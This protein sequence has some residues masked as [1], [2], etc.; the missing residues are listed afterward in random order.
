[1]IHRAT[2]CARVC[3]LFASCHECIRNLSALLVSKCPLS[4]HMSTHG[5]KGAIVQKRAETLTKYVGTLVLAAL[6]FAACGEG[7]RQ[8]RTCEWPTEP[9]RR[10]DLTRSADRAHLRIDAESAETIA[11]HYADVSPARQKGRKEYAQARDECMESLF[12]AVARNHA[13]DIRAVRGYMTLRSGRFDAIVLVSF[14]VVYGLAAYVLAGFI[15]WR[16][17]ADDW[18]VVALAVVGFSLGASVAAMMVFD[19]WAGTAESL[20]LGSWHLSYRRERLPWRQH[21]VLLFASSVGLFWLISLLRYRR[22]T[23][24]GADGAA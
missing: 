11:I 21:R 8:S 23:R 4:A 17:A 19:L 1:M 18:C 15:A 22:P 9:D 5:R 14:T 6:A 7:E 13:L 12:N 16:F 10:L 20:R 24:Q 2:K 3:Y